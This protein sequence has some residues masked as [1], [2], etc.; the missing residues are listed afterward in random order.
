MLIAGPF[1]M[2]LAWLAGGVT[3]HGAHFLERAIGL[4]HS[5]FALD[6]QG[7]GQRQMSM[8]N[9]LSV[10]IEFDNEIDDLTGNI[11]VKNGKHKMLQV[12]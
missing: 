12:S 4:I 1:S 2:R 7:I 10:G 6:Y 11:N 5:M 9:Y 3:A 8:E